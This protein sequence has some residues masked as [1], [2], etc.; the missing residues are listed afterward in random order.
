MASIKI[1]TETSAVIKAVVS[2]SAMLR[3]RCE[4]WGWISWRRGSQAR[5]WWTGWKDGHWALVQCG[6]RRR[7]SIALVRPAGRGALAQSRAVTACGRAHRC[8]CMARLT[9]CLAPSGNG[10]VR[11]RGDYSVDRLLSWRW[12]LPQCPKMVVLSAVVDIHVPMRAVRG[13][14]MAPL[15]VLMLPQGAG[16]GSQR[17]QA[18][19]AEGGTPGETRVRGHVHDRSERL[20]RRTYIRS[21]HHRTNTGK[22]CFSLHL[23]RRNVVS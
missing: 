5:R 22:C 10:F 7:G 19:G 4:E 20:G 9:G 1:F 15:R 3:D 13:G 12:W 17:P 14:A 18:E 16:A 11:G 8:T 23:V 2:V 21:D 6:S